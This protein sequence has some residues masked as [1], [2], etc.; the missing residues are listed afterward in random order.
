MNNLRSGYRLFVWPW[1]RHWF[2]P[3]TYYYWLKYKIQRAQRGWADCDVWSFDDY[4]ASW[5][6][7]ALEHLKKTTHG[8]PPQ[9]FEAVDGVD[10]D[11]NPSDTAMQRAEARWDA[12]LDKMIAG[13]KAWQ[14]IGDS[15]YEDELGPYPECPCA[16]FLCNCEPHNTIIRDRLKKTA[17]L[18][19]RDRQTFR[20]GMALFTDHFGSLWD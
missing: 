11:G 6:P 20:A 13:F 12:T 19:E 14:R 18:E 5:M 10:T 1:W 15:L 3:S 4:L 8:I 2:S 7:D 17:V 9:M 16:K